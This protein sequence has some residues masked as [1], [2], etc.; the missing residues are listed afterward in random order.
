[1]VVLSW[2]NVLLGIW[3]LISPWVLG[4]AGHA[5]PMTNNVITGIVIIIL[6][7]WSALATSSTTSAR[8]DDLPPTV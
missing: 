1:M 4:F 5:T 3:V 8:R 7:A 2:I 6:A